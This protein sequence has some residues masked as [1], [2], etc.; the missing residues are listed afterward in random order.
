MRAN[1]IQ[2]PNPGSRIRVAP[3]QPF[4]GQRGKEL[5][6]KEWVAR[7][8]LVHQLCQGVRVLRRAMQRIG[9][10]RANIVKS[11]RLERDLLDPRSSFADRLERPHKRVCTHRLRCPDTRRPA[12]DAVRQST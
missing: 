9:D 6:R 2:F 5:D 8:L 11:E 12:A 7:R 3:D 1:P 10:E 4:L